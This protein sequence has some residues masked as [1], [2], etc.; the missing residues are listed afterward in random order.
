M[1]TLSFLNTPQVDGTLKLKRQYNR[2][3]SQYRHLESD[4]DT[5]KYRAGERELSDLQTLAESLNNILNQL[6]V[7]SDN[8]I[9]NGFKLN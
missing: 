4:L 1:A 9:T 2:L 7:V 8:E 6:G 5:G 3:L